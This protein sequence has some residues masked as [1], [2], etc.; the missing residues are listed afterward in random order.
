MMIRKAAF[1]LA[2]LFLLVPGLSVHAQEA[3]ED[4]QDALLHRTFYD[5]G[6]VMTEDRIEDGR[7]VNRRFFPGGQIQTETVRLNDTDYETRTYFESG[8]LEGESKE[9][10][11]KQSLKEYDEKGTLRK[12]IVMDE[13]NMTARNFREDGSLESEDAGGVHRVFYADGKLQYEET[14]EDGTGV[15]TVY[16]ESGAKSEEIRIENGEAVHFKVYD[17]EGKAEFDGPLEE[18]L[19][20]YYPEQ[21]TSQDT[22][23]ADA[24]TD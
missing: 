7:M 20:K 6:Q 10:S 9:S 23:D 17:E 4:T 2:V 14:L 18:Y 1:L 12:E 13:G 3:E 16:A 11:T 8:R 24:G 19:A 15:R 5:D 21:S 22:A